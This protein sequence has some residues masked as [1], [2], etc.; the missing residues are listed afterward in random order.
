MKLRKPPNNLRLPAISS[1]NAPL[2]ALRKS[3][4]TSPGITVLLNW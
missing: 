1:H 2:R 4:G 3:S